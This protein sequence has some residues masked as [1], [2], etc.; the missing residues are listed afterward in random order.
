MV[1]IP[2]LVAIALGTSLVLYL[3]RQAIKE[4]SSP[5]LHPFC[6][7]LLSNSILAAYGHVSVYK[8]M[9]QKVMKKGRGI[10]P[11]QQ[12][13]GHNIDPVNKQASCGK[14]RT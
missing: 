2:G 6:V 10:N 1:I 8:R 7:V 12:K 11:S 14:S 3:C 9:E 4:L 13:I 5:R